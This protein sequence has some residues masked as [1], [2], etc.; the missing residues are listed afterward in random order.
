MPKLHAETNYLIKVNNGDI[1]VAFLHFLS[2]VKLSMQRSTALRQMQYIKNY[3]MCGMVLSTVLLLYV[4]AR[5]RVPRKTINILHSQHYDTLTYPRYFPD[6]PTNDNFFRH[7]KSF[8][9]GK[10]FIDVTVVE[11]IFEEFYLPRKSNFFVTCIYS[12]IF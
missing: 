12:L 3:E 9:T 8:Y 5:P 2:S 4:T 1:L 6:L 11:S 7:L 10:M